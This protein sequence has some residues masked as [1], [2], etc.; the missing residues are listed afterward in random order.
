MKKII[1]ILSMSIMF[2]LVGFTFPT[3]K[4]VKENAEV[5]NNT[6]GTHIVP[7]GE[8]VVVYNE[9]DGFANIYYNGESLLIKQ[10][11][12][13]D[14]DTINKC[15]GKFRQKD[16]IIDNRDKSNVIFIGDSRTYQMNKKTDSSL[17][18]WIAESSSEYKWFQQIAIPIMDTTDLKGKKICILMGV[19]DYIVNGISS[20]DNY[21]NFYNTKAQEW[22]NKGASVIF[23]SVMPTNGGYEYINAGIDE[24]NEKIRN[25][26]NS[27]IKYLDLNTFMKTYGFNTVDGIHYDDYTYNVIYSTILNNI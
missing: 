2:L 3:T 1:T 12:L 11:L 15:D 4:Y 20:A 14:F 22:I 13:T 10:S 25:K 5:Y 24:F 23:V 19:N 18:S 7:E 27:N 8:E 17:A 9:Y 26:K 16:L 6:N 21:I